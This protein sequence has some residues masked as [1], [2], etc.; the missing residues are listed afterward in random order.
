MSKAVM[1]AGAWDEK[2]PDML[3]VACSL[4][5]VL[6]E[7]GVTV[8]S[9]GGTGVPYAAL[10]G[11]SLSGGTSVAIIG[12]DRSADEDAELNAVASVRIYTGSGWDGRSVV[13]VKSADVLVAI[14]GRNGTV[15]EITLAYLNQIPTVVLAGSSQSIDRLISALDQG[16]LDERQN[17]RVIVATEADLVDQV[18]DALCI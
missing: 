2:R 16:Y 9:G 5:R 3:G 10:E 11:A 8:I 4:A 1:I 7:R 14:G 18:W 12:Q 15:N 6:A 17:A 13:A